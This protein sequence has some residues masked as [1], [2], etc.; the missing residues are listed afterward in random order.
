MKKSGSLLFFILL[1]FCDLRAQNA[2]HFQHI[3]VEDGLSQSSVNNIFQDA[4]GFIWFATGDGLN[5]YDGKDFISYKSRMN[6]TTSS[7]KDRNIN[8]F[9][10]EDR[11]NR[12]WFS[13]DAGISY[14]DIKKHRTKVVLDKYSAACSGVLLGISNDTLWLAVPTRGV[15]AIDLPTLTTHVYLFTDKL[16]L[17]H[18]TGAIYSGVVQK[19]GIWICDQ[20]GLLYFDRVTK[21]D[22][23]KFAKRDLNYVMLLKN[24]KLL[25][26]A[27]NGI[28][29]Y[30]TAN[31]IVQFTAITGSDGKPLAWDRSI[32][33]YATGIVYVGEHTGGHICKLNTDNLSHEITYLQSSSV[34]TLF[35]DRSRNLWIGTDGNGVFKLDIKKPKF[36]SLTVKEIDNEASEN[37]YMVKSIYR[38]AN[39]KIW[40]GVVNRGL[41]IYDP[42]TKK[43]EDL[44]ATND[45]A[46]LISTIKKDSSGS[47]LVAAGEKIIW[48][49][50][51]THKITN[52]IAITY[53]FSLSPLPS[54]I[55]SVLEWKKGHYMIGTNITF[56]TLWRDGN[57]FNIRA[58]GDDSLISHWYYNISDAGNGNMYLG[59]RDGF[60][61]MRML[62]DTTYELLDNGFRN[63]PIR[64]FYKSTTTPIVWIASE[65]GLIAYNEQTHKHKVFDERT[66]LSNSFVYSILAQD[67]STLWISTN[68]GIH[69]IKVHYNGDAIPQASFTGFTVNDGLQS[70]EF[71]TGAYLKD[72]DGT[73]YFGGIAGIN[74]FHPRDIE[75]NPFKAI[76]AI[77]AIYVNDSMYAGDTT[78]F[79]HSLELPY[80]KN[81]ISFDL[82]ALEFTQPGQNTLAYLLD[83]VDKDWVYT[84]N[85]K[86]RYSALP[87]GTY[88]FR[89]KA[90]NNDGVWN[91]EPLLL[92]ITIQPPYWQTW[93]F[94]SLII[95]G[96]I[97]IS[98]LVVRYYIRLRIKERTLELEKQQ[99]LYMERLRISKDVHDDLGSGLS[100]ISLIAD[101]AQKKTAGDLRL[102]NDIR[103]ISAVSKELVENMRDLIWV[104]NPENTTLEQLVSRL[105]EYCADYLENIPVDL[106]LDFP[107][108]VPDLRINR[109][110]QRNIFLTVKE[111]INNCIKHAD[112]C[113]IKVRLTLNNGALSIAITDNGNGFDSAHLKGSGNGLR[114][115]RQRIESIGGSFTLS[116]SPG[117]STQVIFTIAL[118]RLSA[119]QIPL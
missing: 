25:I 9:L 46:V 11:Y 63:M 102:G 38:D 96:I 107:A 53:P 91:N 21:K 60:V 64:H 75:I 49:D 13:S 54:V 33:D 117:N 62:T 106:Q 18:E 12:I 30:N 57:K 98:Y 6:D 23:R 24:G 19:N 80:T 72:K 103:N 99:A 109:E 27:S 55:Y 58:F 115:M 69:K 100:K 37:G 56:S 5:R 86:V 50:E 15:Y 8:S 76:P 68:K 22:T 67:D 41:V 14:L 101:I 84:T 88:T 73:M 104:L 90:S 48:F 119:E 77:S 85:N 3:N 10:F 28:Y 93:W 1:L 16:H 108:H 94:R 4:H 52:S 82:R 29:Q 20:G 89:L 71:N 42:V 61:K 87:A 40:M 45:P 34:N 39:G 110:V 36:Y 59:L 74:W 65:Q 79:I 114:N 105:R 70:N 2:P 95:A 111:A 7:M 81:T 116:S 32:E 44:H 43:I 113:E 78:I 31:D 47:V 35:I 51:M 26:S 118:S 17:S 97:S 92:T 83:G 112:A 66:G